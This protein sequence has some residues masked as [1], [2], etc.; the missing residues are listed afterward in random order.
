MD[1]TKDDGGAISPKRSVDI[2]VPKAE[3]NADELRLAQM[4]SSIDFLILKSSVLLNL[5]NKAIH[6]S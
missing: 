6:R 4:G 5:Y 2:S 3:M 1:N